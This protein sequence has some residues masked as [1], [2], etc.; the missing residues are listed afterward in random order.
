MYVAQLVLSRDEYLEP[1]SIADISELSDPHV[2]EL[3]FHLNR[4]GMADKAA[5]CLGEMKRRL[6]RLVDDEFETATNGLYTGWLLNCL[7]QLNAITRSEE[8]VR[9]LASCHSESM[10]LAI[11]LGWTAGLRRSHEVRAP[12]RVLKL[13]VSPPVERHLSRHVAVRAA[14]EGMRLSPGEQQRLIPLYAAIY[15]TLYDQQEEVSAPEEPCPSADI[16]TLSH[17]EYS[18]GTVSTYTICFSS[19][20]LGSWNRRALPNA[21][22]RIKDLACGSL[23]H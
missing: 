23:P 2:L 1:R 11:T 15:R 22:S 8:F 16:T 6:G 19:W 20:L 17:Q 21:G 13:P 12:I 5:D 7:A 18:G 9:L 4:R 10:Q 3:G 14:Y